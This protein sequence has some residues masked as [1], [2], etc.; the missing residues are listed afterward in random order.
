[1]LLTTLEII[2]AYPQDK[3]LPRFLLRGNYDG[4]VSTSGIAMDLG[5][6]NIGVVTM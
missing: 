3:Y 5:C 2:E 6:E 4:S 1:M